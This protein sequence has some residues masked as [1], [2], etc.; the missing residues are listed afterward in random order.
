MTVT[1]ALR[2]RSGRSLLKSLDRSDLPEGRCSLPGSSPRMTQGRVRCRGSFARPLLRLGLQ[3]HFIEH[4]RR[5]LVGEV[6]Q[7]DVLFGGA[8]RG[9][10]HGPEVFGFYAVEG[11][12]TVGRAVGGVG[13]GFDAARLA[14]C[15][16]VFGAA[17]FADAGEGGDAHQDADED[18]LV[19]DVDDEAP[20]AQFGQGAG[21]R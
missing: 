15:E 2:L 18:G 1:A 9:F 20:A 11:A 3:Q 19:Q 7:G 21:G 13:G 14:A 5:T 8:L 6:A 16:E 12:G 17:G 10:E 4:L